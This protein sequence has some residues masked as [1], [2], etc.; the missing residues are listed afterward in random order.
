MEY[1][2]LIPPNSADV[3]FSAVSQG[4]CCGLKLQSG[5]RRVSLLCQLFGSV[6]DKEAA[7]K[8]RK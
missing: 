6:L 7:R 8:S 5:G 2:Y 4:S 1:E 3:Q